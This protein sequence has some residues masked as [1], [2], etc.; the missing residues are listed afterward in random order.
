MPVPQGPLIRLAV[1]AVAILFSGSVEANKKT[2]IERQN[3]LFIT[4]LPTDASSSVVVVTATPATTVE[5]PPSQVPITSQAPLQAPTP[6]PTADPIPT[7]FLTVSSSSTIP[8]LATATPSIDPAANASTSTGADDPYS[9]VGNTFFGRV[10]T[11]LPDAPVTGAFLLIFL[12]LAIAHWIYYRASGR[13]SRW[14]ANKADL[15]RL[16]ALF[17][18]ARVAT[19]ILRL[20]WIAFPRSAVVVSVAVITDNAG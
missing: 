7:T 8:P 20:V 14:G 3:P 1:L 15:S 9:V 12:L 11:A 4:E 10:P 2:L 17:C 6:A 18:L 16:A 19:C 13:R 5:V